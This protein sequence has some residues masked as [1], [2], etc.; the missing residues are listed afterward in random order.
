MGQRSLN[1]LKNIGMSFI[2]KGVGILLSFMTLPLTISYLSKVEYG[3][4]MTM[5]TVLNW[6][7]MLD[8]G[9]GLGFRNRLS[10]A[11]SRNEIGKVKDYITTGFCTMGLIALSIFAIFYIIL[12]HINLPLFYNTEKVAVDSLYKATLYAGLF[13]IIS[14]ALSLINNIYYAY[15]K[16]AYASAIQ[17]VHGVVN[18]SI[19]YYLTM[20]SNHNLESFVFSFGI[21]IIVSRVIFIVLFFWMKPTL[22]PHLSHFNTSVLKD[23][24]TLGA[25]FFVIQIGCIVLFASSNLVITQRLGP[26]YVRDYDIAFK[27]FGIVTMMHTLISAPLWNAYTD[28]YVKRDFIWIRKTIYKM[29]ELMI[30]IIGI[31]VFIGY[32]FTLICELWLKKEIV[33]QQPLVIGMSFYAI[34]SCWNNIFAMFVNGIGKIDIQMYTCIASIIFTVP[35]AWYLIPIFGVGG[36]II[37]ISIMLFLTGL[38]ITFQTY[39]ELSE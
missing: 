20:Q 24:F 29:L 30:G 28:A 19:L 33:L 25:K 21:A 31:T 35:L 1:I 7:N 11:V 3:I 4:W 5:F 23:V 14:F 36:M 10:E 37:S 9:F 22:L 2:W 32:N 8:M 12:Q 6:V 34:I 17:I 38:P 15:Q 27:V 26:E 39:K 13:V 18:L 16:A